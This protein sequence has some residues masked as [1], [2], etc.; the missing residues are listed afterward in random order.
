MAGEAVAGPTRT[1]VGRVLCLLTVFG[2]IRSFYNR[3]TGWLTSPDMY[4][5]STKKNE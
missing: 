1:P 5:K 4:S 3:I 2:F